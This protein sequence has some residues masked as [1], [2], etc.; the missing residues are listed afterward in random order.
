MS[1]TNIALADPFAA[2]SITGQRPRNVLFNF[3]PIHS[4]HRDVTS[5]ATQGPTST[6]PSV[7]QLTL[8]KLTESTHKIELRLDTSTIRSIQP[9]RRKFRR[10]I[11]RMIESIPQ[12]TELN[13]VVN[14][15]PIE[16]DLA[17]ICETVTD[18]FWTTVNASLFYRQT[19][20]KYTASMENMSYI[21]NNGDE[22]RALLEDIAFMVEY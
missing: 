9:V 12:L 3:N 17:G 19:L 16:Q 22:V 2:L 1:I 21:A 6:P 15:E 20:I 11:E 13:V 5:I 8:E 4:V 7:Q 10:D 18:L 14:I